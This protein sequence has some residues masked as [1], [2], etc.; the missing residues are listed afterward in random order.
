LKIEDWGCFVKV[1]IGVLGFFFLGGGGGGVIT[2]D[3]PNNR[4]CEFKKHNNLL[5]FLLFGP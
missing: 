1:R 4:N 2:M 3:A 5:N